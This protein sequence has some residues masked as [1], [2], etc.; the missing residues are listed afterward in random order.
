MR[1]VVTVNQSG[2]MHAGAQ[3]TFQ[4]PSLENGATHTQ[5]ASSHL[6]ASSQISPEVCLREFL[7]SSQVVVETETSHRARWVLDKLTCVMI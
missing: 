1:P 3:L 2:E 5:G 7:K 6:E 4:D